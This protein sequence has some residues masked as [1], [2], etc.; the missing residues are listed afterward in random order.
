MIDELYVG[1]KNPA[2]IEAVKKVFSTHTKLIT[3][4]V[5]SDVSSQ[6]FS[7]LET[8]EGAVNRAKYLLDSEKASFGLGLEGGVVEDKGTMMLCNWGA[9]ACSS[10]EVYVA[11]GARIV[12]PKT[13]AD[14]VRDGMELGD[15]ID[16]WSNR[17]G[18]KK[19]EGTIGILTDGE[20]TRVS[21][22]EHV[23]RLLYGQWK[24]TNKRSDV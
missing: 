19:K 12:I 21:M 6:P 17:S 8:K 3:L 24:F 18:V 1:T 2:K 20:V 13:I 10:G 14:K 23:V 9:L 11:G 15:A 7:D 5:P 16:E 22:F 4:D